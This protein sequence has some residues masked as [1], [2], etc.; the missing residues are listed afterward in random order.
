[1]EYGYHI[2]MD[3]P[4]RGGVLILPGG[5]PES[6]RGSR[7]WQLANQRMALLAGSLR[8]R[9]GQGVRVAA[10]LAAG[11]DIGAIVAL[12]EPKPPETYP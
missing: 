10:H 8:R 3:N 9:L 1:M 2:A 12:G 5:R 7:P 11:G 6:S 4:L